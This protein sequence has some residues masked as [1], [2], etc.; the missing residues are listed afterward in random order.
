[1]A[2]IA[3]LAQEAELLAKCIGDSD[4]EAWEQF[5]RNYSGLIWG[6]IRRTFASYSFRY[7]NEDIE[8]IYG[9]VFYDL[10]EN[11]FKKIR[12][13]R[14]ENA[15]SLNTWLTIIAVRKTID[16][17]RQDKR[18]LFIK[19]GEEEGDIWEAIPENSRSVDCLL[20]EGE[21]RSVIER[22]AN[23]LPRNDRL[24][25]CLLYEKGCSAAEAAHILGLQP[26]HI[27]SRKHRIIEKIK[28]ILE[29][30]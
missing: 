4:P 20:E 1:M 24:I 13:F 8:D 29:A 19:A 27:Y 11:D 30:M 18:H 17:L 10:V 28:K 21:I 2:D 16:F 9:A 26:A 22:A 12:Q 5:V 3:D 25:Y 6:A 7:S 15:C 14:G 23:A